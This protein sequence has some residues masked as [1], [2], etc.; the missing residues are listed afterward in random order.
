MNYILD[1]DINIFIKNFN[2]DLIWLNFQEHKKEKFLLQK[3]E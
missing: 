3:E 2:S 1:L